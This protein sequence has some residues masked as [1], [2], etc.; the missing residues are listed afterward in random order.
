MKKLLSLASLSLL[1]LSSLL[2]APAQAAAVNSNFNVT[3]TL[4]SVCQVKTASAAGLVFTYSAFQAA[5]SAGIPTAVVFECTRGLGTAPTVVLDT[6]TDASSAVAGAT[7]SGVGVVGGLQYSVNVAAAT[8]ATG[9]AA[10]TSSIGSSTTYSYAITGSMPAGQAGTYSAT[11][12]SQTR[13]L[14]VTY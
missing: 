8:V 13:T 10:S 14:T 6:A 1:A 12:A 5:A 4:T 9:T 2:T 3:V 11:A 7:T